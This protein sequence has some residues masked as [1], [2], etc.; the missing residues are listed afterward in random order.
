[1]GRDST[2]RPMASRDWCSI[3]SQGLS[4]LPVREGCNARMMHTWRSKQG[5][6]ACGTMSIWLGDRS[7]RAVSAIGNGRWPAICKKMPRIRVQRLRAEEL[8]EA[9]TKSVLG[10]ARESDSQERLPTN[11]R[12]SERVEAGFEMALSSDGTFTL[13]SYVAPGSAQAPLCWESK[14]W[15]DGEHSFFSPRERQVGGLTLMLTGRELG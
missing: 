7:L 6:Y 1:M 4:G 14:V 8:G 5:S 15:W 3:N 9:G 11:S 13:R 10:R 12:S 2:R